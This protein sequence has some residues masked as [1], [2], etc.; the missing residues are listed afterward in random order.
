M[1]D[2]F[3]FDSLAAELIKEHAKL[4]KAKQHFERLRTDLLQKMQKENV[5]A[6]DVKEGSVVMCTR[7][8]KDYGQTIK[9][10]EANL[11]AEK[12]RLD[13]LG[14]FIIKNVTHY[15]R[16]DWIKRGDNSPPLFHPNYTKIMALT[17]S[18]FN[19]CSIKDLYESMLYCAT[20]QDNYLDRMMQNP[21]NSGKYID[22]KVMMLEW[23]RSYDAARS[24]LEVKFGKTMRRQI[25]DMIDKDLALVAQRRKIFG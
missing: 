2:P 21:V 16:V 9:N 23:E 22:A 4:E 11:K 3:S 5:G 8:T 13:H 12:V 19:D 17:V 1:S 10:M 14:E 25:V 7:T 20:Q 15:L 18:H 24:A 6:I